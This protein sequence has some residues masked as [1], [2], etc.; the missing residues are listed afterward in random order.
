MD[1]KIKSELKQKLDATAYEV[2]VNKGTEHPHSGKYNKHFEKGVY[3]CVAC[4]Q[5][6]F[7]SD[8]K[9]DA[10][11]G[12]PSFDKEIKSDAVKDYT[13][14]THGMIRT[15]ITSANCDAHLGHVFED[16]PTETNLRYCVNSVSLDFED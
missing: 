3:K 6:L 7:E 4:G 2:V 11:C 13:D 8:S 10:G 12:W 15:E 14:N 9:F 16:G 1:S 5:A